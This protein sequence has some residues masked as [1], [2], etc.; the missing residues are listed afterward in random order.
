MTNDP[1]LFVLKKLFVVRGI[2]YLSL[3][4]LFIK[5]SSQYQTMG[6]YLYLCRHGER[7]DWRGK[8]MSC[9]FVSI[10]R[11]L[12]NMA[13]FV[14]HVRKSLLWTGYLFL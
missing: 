5:V 10:R 2:Y 4:Q 14:N 11:Y 13:P 7:G 1:T 3:L 9:R 8:K 12:L 6:F